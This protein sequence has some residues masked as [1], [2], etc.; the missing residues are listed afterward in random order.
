[1]KPVTDLL[2]RRARRREPTI[3]FPTPIEA[4]TFA[5]AQVRD[6]QNIG[7]GELLVN[8]EEYSLPLS[9]L[10]AVLDAVLDLYAR[11]R[12]EEIGR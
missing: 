1:M 11:P 4:V 8:R 3:H 10:D 9:Q 12:S 7:D 6:L 2:A 5:K